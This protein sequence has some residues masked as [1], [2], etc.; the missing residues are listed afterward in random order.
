M[1]ITPRPRVYTERE[2]P[3]RDNKPIG[4]TPLHRDV[5]F[6]T[7]ALLR[8]HFAN[9]PGLYISGNM[10]L[11]YVEGDRRKHVSPDVFAARGIGNGYRDRYFVWEEGKGPDVVLE[12]SSRSTRNDDLKKKFLLYQDTLKVP[13][14]FLFDPKAEY[15]IPPL[16]GYRLAQGQYQPID[17]VADRLPSEVLG[18]HLERHG[19]DL[20][21]YDPATG[22]LV[23]TSSEIEAALGQQV[24]A[25]RQRAEAERQRAEA[26][27][28]HSAQLETTL[29]QSRAEAERLRHELE[30]LRRGQSHE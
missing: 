21:F 15:L 28:Q 27:R 18:L 2:Y 24:E 23:P 25:E 4:E 20:R 10:L 11:Y 26:E 16:R 22:R 6:E 1:A 29:E 30:E 17:A 14:Y 5:L 9:D 3:S 7:I 12:I 8:Q 19:T 13:E